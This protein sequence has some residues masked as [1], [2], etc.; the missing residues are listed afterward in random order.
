M[1]PWR[2][3]RLGIALLALAMASSG[4][5]GAP[6]PPPPA[7]SSSTVASTST[8]AGAASPVASLVPGG[9][10]ATV[11]R[12]VDGDTIHARVDGADEKVRIIGLDSPETNKPA[13]P[14]ECFARQATAAAK[15]LLSPGDPITLQPD[16]TQDERDRFGRLLAHVVLANGTLFAEQMIEG[17]WAIH[18]VY[19]GV[20][21][22]YAPRLQAAEDRP[23]AA[24]RGLWSPSTCGGD[25]HLSSATP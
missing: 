3:T 25:P 5:G 18:Y 10:P 7:G 14:V 23:K 21:S 11:I 9:T 12:V 24:Q 19:D 17:G 8:V 16:P 6:P 4:C 1:R 22:M 15:N 13:T 2:S 20:P